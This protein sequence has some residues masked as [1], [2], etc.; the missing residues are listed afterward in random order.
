MGKK[1]R[2]KKLK[3]PIKNQW[4]AVKEVDGVATKFITNDWTEFER[5]VKYH[6]VK[7]RTCRTFEEAEGYVGFFGDK[8]H[9]A[10]ETVVAYVDGSYNQWEK[11]FS[12]GVFLI[13]NNEKLYW[14]R[15][16][17]DKTIATMRNV[18]GEI[19]AATMAMEYA[20]KHNARKL[21][22]FYD[23]AGIELLAKKKF[24]PKRNEVQDYVLHCNE[25]MKKLDI[26]FR[27]VKGHSGDYGN[28]VADRLAKHAL[29]GCSK[30]KPGPEREIICTSEE[31]LH[32]KQ[33]A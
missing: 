26:E 12:S 20:V 23:Y 28:D 25:V 17:S 13:H 30:Y 8:K 31:L 1:K 5:I 11:R 19:Q 7:S 29:R 6:R 9:S 33:S 18:A 16:S 32:W 24:K 21:V 3:C 14:A 27:Y 10:N 22:L 4:Y 2:K 15:A